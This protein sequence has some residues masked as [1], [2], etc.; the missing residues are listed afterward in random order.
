MRFERGFDHLHQRLLL[1]LAV[2]DDVAAEEPVARVLA[3]GLGDVEELDVGG[4]ALHVRLKEVGVVVEVP[5][6]EGEA[7]LL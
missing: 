6:V 1:P 4:V 3:V 5:V 7:H 2:D